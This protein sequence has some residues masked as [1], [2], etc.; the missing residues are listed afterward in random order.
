MFVGFATLEHATYICPCEKHGSVLSC[1]SENISQKGRNRLRRS[2]KVYKH[3]DSRHRHTRD[4]EGCQHC[5]VIPL[6][7]HVAGTTGISHLLPVPSGFH[8][9]THAFGALPRV[10]IA[11]HTHVTVRVGKSVLSMGTPQCHLVSTCTRVV[12]VM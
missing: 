3:R 8:F 10:S 6:A 9:H 12:T 7:K 2:K 4:C 1:R 5:V 11:Q